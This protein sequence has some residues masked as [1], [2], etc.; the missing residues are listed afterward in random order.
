MPLGRNQAFGIVHTKTD[1]IQASTEAIFTNLKPYCTQ[2]TGK[3]IK[4][5]FQWLK[6]NSRSIILNAILRSK[7]NFISNFGI[8]ICDLG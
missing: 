7:E 2:H 5:C 8:F 6:H 3:H 4:G 1:I